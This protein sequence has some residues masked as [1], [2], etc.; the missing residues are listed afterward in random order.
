MRNK[1]LKILG[2]PESATEQDIKK[3]YRRKAFLF[4]PDLNDSPNAKEEFV[5]IDRAYQYLISAQPEPQEEVFQG[6]PLD[7]KRRENAVIYAQF[8][9]EFKKKQE[10][11][12][13]E[14]IERRMSKFRKNPLFD[15]A[16]SFLSIFIVIYGFL[17]LIDQAMSPIEETFLSAGVSS[18]DEGFYHINLSRDKSITAIVSY[19]V[20]YR[21]NLDN[22][23]MSV[24]DLKVSPI[25]KT[26]ETVR[27]VNN[28]LV[29]DSNI[30]GDIFYLYILPITML[31]PLFWLFYRRSTHP[32]I[33]LGNGI[34]IVYPIIVSVHMYMSLTFRTGM[35]EGMI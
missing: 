1:Y 12:Y 26:P 25:F 21:T 10:K 3:A 28:R 13:Q 31:L 24:V 22:S 34:L 32:M 35:I 30:I 5:K 11:E 9:K 2:L 16:I 4:H 18:G 33:I 23:G 29:G 14:K 19:E 27:L 17:F 20:A 6:N 8:A 15:V 7:Q